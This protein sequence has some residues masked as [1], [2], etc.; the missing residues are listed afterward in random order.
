MCMKENNPCS[1][2]AKGENC[3]A[4]GY[5][6]MIWLTSLVFCVFQLLLISCLHGRSISA[7]PPVGPSCSVPTSS[8]GY[9]ST[10]EVMNAV[11]SA[12][13]ALTAIQS[14]RGTSSNPS[15]GPSAD[16]SSRG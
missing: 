6:A 10:L 7:D 9:T 1:S 4:G 15:T 5:P 16:T 8:S 12:V 3:K 11:S 13:D 2:Y 14:S